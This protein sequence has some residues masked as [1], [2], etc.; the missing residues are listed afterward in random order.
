MQHRSMNRW[1]IAVPAAIALA[2]WFWMPGQRLAEKPTPADAPRSS[3]LAVSQPKAPANTQT[4]ATPAPEAS[5]AMSSPNWKKHA[6]IAF[7]D[8]S[9]V[10]VTLSHLQLPSAYPWPNRVVDQYETLHRLGERGDTDAARALHQYLSTCRNAHG[11]EA[12]LERAVARLHREGVVER[13]GVPDVVIADG[14]FTG[15]E[16]SMLRGQYEFCRG[17][18]AEQKAELPVWTERAA[19]AGDPFAITAWARSLGDTAEGL[20]AWEAAW[21]NGVRSAPAALATLYER[22]VPGVSGGQANYV[23]AYAFGLIAWKLHEAWYGE[24]RSP[25]QRNDL[26]AMEGS[27]RHMGGFLTPQEQAQAVQ[28]ARQL[29]EENPKC[30]SGVWPGMR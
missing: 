15:A 12:S 2:A 6:V 16:L 13:P 30:C 26:H 21:R 5:G 8:G 18:T 3:P 24:Q 22:G 23:R 29:L 10:R 11:D 27:L 17:L 9:E 4:V 20:A 7:P 1:V 14:N 25:A 28:L 19:R